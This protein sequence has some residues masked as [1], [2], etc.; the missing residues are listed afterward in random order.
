MLRPYK[1][2]G[3]SRPRSETG[4]GEGDGKAAVGDVVGGLHR[5]LGGE[6]Y[7]AVLKALLGGEVDGRCFAGE[8]GGDRLG[9]FGGGEF[10]RGLGNKKSRFLVSLGMTRRGSVAIE[11][12][13]E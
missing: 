5:A 12:D 7:E 10:A 6:S 8:D 9:V 1:R 4:L 2:G 3:R 13:N 11:K